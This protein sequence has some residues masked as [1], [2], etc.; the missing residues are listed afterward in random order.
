[1]AA[2]V[3][4]A[5]GASLVVAPAASADLIWYQAVGSVREDAP[6]P[7]SDA[8]DLQAGWTSWM[9]GWEQWPHGGQG[10]WIC[11]RSIVWGKDAPVP[12][13]APVF[14]GCVLLSSLGT[15][16]YVDFSATFIGIDGSPVFGDS[17][18]TNQIGTGGEYVYASD[19]SQAGALCDSAWPGFFADQPSWITP[20]FMFSCNAPNYR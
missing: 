11:G 1:M 13:P 10:G 12:A 3:M 9:R 18:C 2:A 7:T 4:V 5:G 16:Q 15:V 19:I 8:A 14:P 17:G 6:C 20:P